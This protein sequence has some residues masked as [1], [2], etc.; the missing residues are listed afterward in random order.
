VYTLKAE[1]AGAEGEE[2][3]VVEEEAEG[4]GAVDVGAFPDR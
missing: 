4:V 3:E 2:D 1:E